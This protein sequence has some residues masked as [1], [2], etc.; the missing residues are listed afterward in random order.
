MLELSNRNLDGKD[1]VVKCHLSEMDSEEYHTVKISENFVRYF[2]FDP[3]QTL[4]Y[5]K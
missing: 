1:S 5:E 4:A 2:G 3:T